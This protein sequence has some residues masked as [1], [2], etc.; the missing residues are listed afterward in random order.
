MATMHMP[1]KQQ[2][3]NIN[4]NYNS[5]ILLPRTAKM[6]IMASKPPNVVRFKQVTEV[7]P[8]QRKRILDNVFI[9]VRSE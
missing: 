4:I 7:K 9:N 1:T 2:N 5:N 6:V 3:C 8:Y